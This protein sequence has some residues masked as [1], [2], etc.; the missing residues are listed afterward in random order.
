MFLIIFAETDSA[1]LTALSIWWLQ[2]CFFVHK[3]LWRGKHAQYPNKKAD[4]RSLLSVV[5]DHIPAWYS[6]HHCAATCSAGTC[7][8]KVS[9]IKAAD[10]SLGCLESGLAWHIIYDAAKT[11]QSIG[12]NL[13]PDLWILKA[14]CI[15]LIPS[16]RTVACK[17]L[18]GFSI[19][20]LAN[21]VSGDTYTFSP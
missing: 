5:Q 14:S 21:F 18:K 7:E 17:F 16:H 4:R 1:P 19:I 8:D 15:P 3:I 2:S 10:G 20:V 13:I 12:M 6:E 9:A 11:E